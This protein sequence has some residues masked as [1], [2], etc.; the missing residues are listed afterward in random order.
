MCGEFVDCGKLTFLE[1]VHGVAHIRNLRRLQRKGVNEFVKGRH[2]WY[3]KPPA[4]KPAA[5]EPA[6]RKTSAKKQ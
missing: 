2:D 1:G 3:V 6:A 4:N 5:K